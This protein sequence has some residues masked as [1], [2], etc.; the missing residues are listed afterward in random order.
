[1]K[2]IS[3]YSD[4]LAEAFKRIEELE[5]ENKI[6][7]K[8]I[9]KYRRTHPRSSTTHSM[10]SP[11]LS[12]SPHYTLPTLSSRNK[13]K[14]ELQDACNNQR[15]SK[16]PTLFISGIPYRYKDCVPRQVFKEEKRSSLPPPPRC[17]PGYMESTTASRHHASDGWAW[18]PKTP[19]R[20]E[21]PGSSSCEKIHPIPDPPS[22]SPPTPL[23]TDTGVEVEIK[24]DLEERSRLDDNLRFK[25]EVWTDTK[26]NLKYLRK[27]SKIVQKSIFDARKNGGLGIRSPE[28]FEDGPHTILLGRDELMSWL[29]DV[30]PETLLAYNG[31]SSQQVYCSLLGT[32]YLRNTISHPSAWELQD[33]REVDDLLRRAQRVAIILGNEEGTLE[34]RAMRDALRDA[35]SKFLQC[36]KDLYYMTLLPDCDM[37]EFGNHHKRLFKWALRRSKNWYEEERESYKEVLAVASAWNLRRQKDGSD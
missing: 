4:R 18:P 17:Y 21:I 31:Y 34:I 13:D 28:I 30:A 25:I 9:T 10:E 7:R 20:K 24:D 35:A 32:V 8:E 3:Q 12:G 23:P 14:S 26:T 2:Y 11:G 37:P 36:I 22:T 27:A 15:E 16:L 1:M 5:N 29:G 19:W 33:S 6:L